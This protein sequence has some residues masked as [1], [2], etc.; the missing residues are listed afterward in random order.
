[1][2]PYM[3]APDPTDPETQRLLADIYINVRQ[4]EQFKTNRIQWESDTQKVLSLSLKE[5]NLGFIFIYNLYYLLHIFKIER[6]Q[7][8]L[9]PRKFDKLQGRT[10]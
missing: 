5:I 9:K 3:S 6:M 8:F 7:I 1:M 2:H 4:S 10:K